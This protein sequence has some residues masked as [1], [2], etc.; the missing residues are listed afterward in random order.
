MRL[1]AAGRMGATLA[2][3]AGSV[4]GG[5]I[6]T[7]PAEAFQCGY[8]TNYYLDGP[9]HVEGVDSYICD[10]HASAAY[11]GIFRNGTLVASGNGFVTY[12]CNGGAV[13]E[14]Q[15]EFANSSAG[16]FA[17]DCG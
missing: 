15:F 5:V 2:L 14:Y 6:A 7:A 10:Y 1:G 8:S 11:V 16:P 17:V 13:N 9:S 3:V 4:T 12:N